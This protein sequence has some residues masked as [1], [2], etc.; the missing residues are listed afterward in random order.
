MSTTTCGEALRDLTDRLNAAGI[1]SARLDARLLLAHA[2]GISATAVFS[3][4]E[5]P[6]TPQD[7]ARIA[8]AADRRLRREPVS[9]IVGQRE[10]WSLPFRITRDTLDPRP[11]TETVVEAAL[12]ALA[13]RQAPLRL[14]DL[15]TGSGCLLLALLSELPRATGLGVD[16]S[17]AA[18]A[19]AADN[20]RALGLDAR[21]RFVA[22]DW[23]KEI[24]GPFDVIVANPP[25]IAD[26]EIARL[27]PEVADFDPPV[28][29]AGGA[30]GLGCYRR[31]VPDL[32]R[33]LRAGGIA[34]LELGQGQGE[35][36]TAILQACGLVVVGL[37]RDLA[38]IERC[39]ICCHV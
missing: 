31:I 27:E 17:Q 5:R 28:A 35:A 25:Y 33:L 3:R 10:F 24:E 21:T 20:A 14:L 15:G 38:G 26:Q 11:D 29:L 2:L 23:G 8:A 6:L 39:V 22:G 13:D 32:G 19:V 4:P 1:A 16:I 37:R 36:V 7:E 12:A 9:R 30:E 18:L 34:A